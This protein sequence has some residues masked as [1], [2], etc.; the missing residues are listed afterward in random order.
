MKKNW[1]VE[2]RDGCYPYSWQGW[3]LSFVWVVFNMFVIINILDYGW[4]QIVIFIIS[5]GILL[6]YIINKKG[7]KLD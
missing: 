6:S 2:R 4:L 3:L 7:K 1:F 5:S